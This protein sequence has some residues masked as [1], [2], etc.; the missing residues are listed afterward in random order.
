MAAT[1]APLRALVLALVP[2]AACWQLLAHPPAAASGLLGVAAVALAGL[3]LA[4]LA[5]AARVGIAVTSRPLTGRASALREKARGAVFQR[6][7]NPDAAGR[8][9]PRAPGAVPAAA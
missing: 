6:Q 7:L 5:H 1:T 4:F 8:A 2:L 9:R 3:A